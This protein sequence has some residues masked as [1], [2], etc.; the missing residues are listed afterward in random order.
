MQQQRIIWSAIAFSTI[1]YAIIVYTAV[2]AP[3]APFDES[4]QKPATL[5]LYAA[6]FAAFVAGLVLPSLLTQ[7]PSQQ[8]LVLT[9]AI[10]ESCAVFGLLAAF[11]AQDWRLYIP[12]WIAALAGFIRAWPGQDV[13]PPLA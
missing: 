8:K 7:S 3:S 6:A 13:R 9:M 5:A 11:L 12:A 4:M 1:L 10:F 2:P